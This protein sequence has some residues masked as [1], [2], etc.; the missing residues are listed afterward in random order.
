MFAHKKYYFNK[1]YKYVLKY[2][3]VIQNMFPPM[4]TIKI[5]GSQFLNGSRRIGL[6]N[7]DYNK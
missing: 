7:S 6:L 5:F 3:F 4:V 2:R 1:L